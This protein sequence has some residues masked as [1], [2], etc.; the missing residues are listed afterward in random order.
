MNR[1]ILMKIK[2]IQE[3]TIYRVETD[4]GEYTRYSEDHWAVTMGESEEPFYACED[5]ERQFKSFLEHRPSVV[6]TLGV[7]RTEPDLDASS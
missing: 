2:Q 4:K 3:V 5:L 6:A 1:A 7:H